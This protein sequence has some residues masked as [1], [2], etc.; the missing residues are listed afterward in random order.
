M[1]V[2]VI[3]PTR[4]RA[5][6]WAERWATAPLARQTVQPLELVVAIDH[7]DDNTEQLIRHLK[8]PFPVRILDVLAGR[9][10]PNPASAVP[11][12]CLFAAARGEVLL[13][14]DDD[15]RISDTLV[16]DTI[17]LHTKYSRSII[18]HHNVFVDAQMHSL[19]GRARED[20]RAAHGAKHRWPILEPG[21]MEIPATQFMHWGASWSVPAAEI[22]AIGGHCLA[23][24]QFHNSDTRLGTRLAMSGV[25]SL[26]GH[27]PA[28]SVFHQGSTWHELHKDDRRALRESRGPYTGR[29]IANGGPNFW[30]SD[31]IK[32]A[33]RELDNSDSGTILLPRAAQ[34]GGIVVQL[35][36]PHLPQSRPAQLVALPK[37]THAN[38]RTAE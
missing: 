15:I 31:W 16:E 14:I 2:S 4:C 9:P 24:A 22:R 35:A 30:H 21:I 1:T 26:L 25:R 7:T 18:W 3:I 10:G 8:L 29:R 38:F 32:A 28:L 34:A 19:P 33:Y 17:R 12:N 27:S 23:L 13:H 20:C 6:L 36:T 11:D 37:E 5:R